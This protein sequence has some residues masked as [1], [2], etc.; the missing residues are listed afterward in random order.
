MRTIKWATIRIIYDV[1]V[2]VRAHVC[3]LH[4]CLASHTRT[5][6]WATIRWRSLSAG[7][8]ARTPPRCGANTSIRGSPPTFNVGGRISAAVPETYSEDRP[9][10]WS[11]GAAT[12]AGEGL[13]AEVLSILMTTSTSSRFQVLA[14][15]P[16]RLCVCVCVC[17]RAQIYTHNVHAQCTCVMQI[18]YTCMQNTCTHDTCT[19]RMCAHAPILSLLRTRVRARSLARTE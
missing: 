17:A 9:S 13:R 7:V 4:Y 3:V 15:L 10:D 11:G 18:P 6:K 14:L 5:I 16:G 19:S 1:C 2:F 8:S 12:V